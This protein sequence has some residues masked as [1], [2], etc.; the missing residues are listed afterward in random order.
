[1]SDDGD[2]M[3]TPDGWA[4]KDV[5]AYRFVTNRPPPRV[6]GLVFP[7]RYECRDQ[8]VLVHWL[9]GGLGLGGFAV[10]GLWPLA[11][12]G[13]ASLALWF[14][15]YQRVARAYRSGRAL[16]GQITSLGP[17]PLLPDGAVATT[18]TADGRQV[19]L[20]LPWSRH[21]ARLIVRDGKAEVLFMD[22]PQC[23]LSPVFAVRAVRAETPAS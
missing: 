2:L 22:S 9:F 12:I 4:V 18:W 3:I 6:L 20:V 1:V 15:L 8:R 11:F 7:L 14:W 21:A 19:H 23:E 16:T 13:L 5:S 10:T 17:H